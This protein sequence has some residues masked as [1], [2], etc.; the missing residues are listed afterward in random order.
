MILSEGRRKY[1]KLECALAA[2]VF[3]A[4]FLEAYLNYVGGK[5]IGNWV[6]LERG[7]EPKEKLKKVAADLG[8]TLDL[9]SDEYASFSRLFELRDELAHGKHYTANFVH[10]Q[11]RV[12][13]DSIG[14]RRETNWTQAWRSKDFKKY[15]KAA[16][17]L[18]RSLHQR[19]EPGEDPFAVHESRHT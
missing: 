13:P 6:D 9:Q 16:E 17:R 7:L 12:T 10:N 4:F 2:M 8:Y 3:S 19:F 15:F 18:V 5:R 11:Q 14:L 1:R